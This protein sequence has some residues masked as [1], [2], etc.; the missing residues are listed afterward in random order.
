MGAK[1]PKFAVLMNGFTATLK[2]YSARRIANLLKIPLIETNRLGHCTDEDGLLDDKLRERR[3]RI[4]TDQASMLI[5]KGL[6]VVVDG[7]FNF[8]RWRNRLYRPLA[9]HGV[10]DVVIVRCVCYDEDIIK[11][12]IAVRQNKKVVPE[13][14]AARMENYLKTRADDEDVREDI[15]PSGAVP[16]VVEFRTGP[17]YSVEVT[18]GH[19]DMAEHIRYLL[20]E[21]F[22]TGKLNEH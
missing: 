20:W 22:H 12:R 3:Y 1:Y 9:K 5:R 7:T 19:S 2:T 6:P 15:L 8:Q 18:Q 13:N 17:E 4:A 14:E 21:S 10:E 16:S 11:A